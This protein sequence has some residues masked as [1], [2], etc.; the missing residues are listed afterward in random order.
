M[1]IIE[2]PWGSEELLAENEIYILKRLTMKEDH[3][4]SLQYH[5]EKHET[6]YLVE[7]KL[8]IIHGSDVDELTETVMIPG[9]V[10]VVPPKLIHRMKALTDSMYLEASTPQLD[11]VVRL[12]DNYGR[13]NET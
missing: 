8:L 1:A 4:C 3:C 13:T 2:K 5:E 12:Q 7:G 11:D 9:D 6:V 10:F